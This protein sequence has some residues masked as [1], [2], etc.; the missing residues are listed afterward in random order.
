VTTIMAMTKIKKSLSPR[1][2]SRKSK[3]PFSPKRVMALKLLQK[4]KTNVQINVIL[5][6]KFG[7]G[8]SARDLKEL[9]STLVVVP[10][11]VKEFVEIFKELYDT[12]ADL[13]QKSNNKTINTIVHK[14]A[15][16]RYDLLKEEFVSGL[17]SPELASH[18]AVVNLINGFDELKE[19]MLKKNSAFS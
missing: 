1:K 15:D 11:S 13:Y 18:K 10:A 7:S 3:I 16:L 5:Q 14:Y 17:T 6:S 19:E 4:K 2:N 8:L 9:R 12:L